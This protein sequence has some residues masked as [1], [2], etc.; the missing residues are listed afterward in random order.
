MPLPFSVDGRRIGVG[1][2]FQST[3][4]VVP[5]LAHPGEVDVVLH[6]V[7]P[8]LVH[9]RHSDLELI[10]LRL[11]EVLLRLLR[12]SAGRVFPHN[13]SIISSRARKARLDGFVHLTAST[14]PSLLLFLLLLLLL[15]LRKR[16]KENVVRALTEMGGCVWYRR[17]FR[18]TYLFITVYIPLNCFISPR[19]TRLAIF[20]LA[21][22]FKMDVR[23]II[24]MRLSR[25]ACLSAP[26]WQK[27][28]RRSR[29][30]ASTPCQ[31]SLS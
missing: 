21:S 17:G 22:A 2:L 16:V 31:P 14:A 19:V 18:K 15:I 3:D 25:S 28:R 12:H 27:R 10:H 6:E 26:S 7:I 9:A 11:E 29:V 23:G 24:L 8:A 4:V 1:R 5:P 20:L 30:V 13:S